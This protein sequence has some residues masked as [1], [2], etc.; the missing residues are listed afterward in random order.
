[1]SRSQGH[2]SDSFRKYFMKLSDT[3]QQRVYKAQSSI[4]LYN[5]KNY[6]IQRIEVLLNNGIYEYSLIPTR[7]WFPLQQGHISI[8][9]VIDKSKIDNDIKVDDVFGSSDD[10]RNRLVMRWYEEENND[11]SYS[12]Y[13]SIY[14][15]PTDD[16]LLYFK[17][18]ENVEQVTCEW[19]HNLFGQL[20]SINNLIGNNPHYI[21]AIKVMADYLYEAM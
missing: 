18:I 7:F 19:F 15:V 2:G 11:L 3:Y 21:K 10:R 16:I 12:A 17:Y 20:Y 9:F 1:M 4:L 6:F 13:Q 14:I 5:E 8:C